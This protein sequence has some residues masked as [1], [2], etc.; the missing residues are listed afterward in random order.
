MADF[1]AREFR[2]ARIAL[3]LSAVCFTVLYP[4]NMWGD[5]PGWMWPTPQRNLPFE[6]MLVAMYMVSGVFLF[7]AARDPVRFL[8]LIDFTIV[9]NVVHG[10]VMLNDA[11]RWG[12]EA[13]LRPG[14]DVIGTFI[15]PVLLIL[16]HPRR[17][18]LGAL[19]TKPSA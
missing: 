3:M 4:L 6:N 12:L 5:D 13:N 2:F 8:P 7:W 18:Y 14:G 10:F 9:A 17:F 1:L 16:T 19:F 15:V 11:L